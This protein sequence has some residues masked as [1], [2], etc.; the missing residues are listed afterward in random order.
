MLIALL[1]K[2]NRVT[3]VL[4]LAPGVKPQDLKRVDQ[5]REVAD[6]SIQPGWRYD[7]RRDRFTPPRTTRSAA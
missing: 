4:A 7:P 1:D 5:W 3:N 2:Q 6:R